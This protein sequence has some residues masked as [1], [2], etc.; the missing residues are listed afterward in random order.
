MLVFALGMRI[1]TRARTVRLG[2][3]VFVL[4][5]PVI[6]VWVFLLMH[7]DS[8]LNDRFEFATGMVTG[9]IEITHNLAHLLL[10]PTSSFLHK[11][12]LS[13]SSYKPKHLFQGL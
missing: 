5:L 3:A 2:I 6:C 1:M 7:R 9:Q 8:C 10:L 11:D 12:H 13:Q 4:P